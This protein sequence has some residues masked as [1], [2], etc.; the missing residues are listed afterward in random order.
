MSVEDFV[1]KITGIYLLFRSLIR[2]FVPRKN[3]SL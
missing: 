3:F 1:K 2:I